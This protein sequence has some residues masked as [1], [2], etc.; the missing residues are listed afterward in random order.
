MSSHKN[1]LRKA[2][3]PVAGLGTRF[4]PVTKASPKEMLPVVDKPLIQYAVEEAV[5][6][7]I[8]VLIFVNN[9][10]KRAIEDYFDDARE[11][12][13]HLT[14]KNRPKLLEKI[15]DI[16]PAGV[17]CVYLRQANSDGLGDAVRCAEAVVHDEPFAVL[18]ADD[19]VR[20]DG[21]GCMTQLTRVWEREGGTVLALEEV[22]PENTSRYGIIGGARGDD[23]LWQV[24]QLVEKPP[25]GEA[26]SRMAVIGRYILQPDIFDHLRNT[27]PGVGGELQLTDAIAKQIDSQPVHG[28]CY[29]GQRYDCGDKL[30]YLRAN[31][32]YALQH[33]DL[34]DDFR[35][36][37]KNLELP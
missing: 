4:L 37:L 14:R 9:R 34:A 20:T 28:L 33:P 5:E 21:A 10:N 6:A 16:V 2:V 18:L 32:E 22:A 31:V 29:D 25:S 19:L 27:R 12:S 17:S 8:E 35:D 15:N 7:G 11:L 1:K 36:Y 13:D 30:G 26:P 24:E 23:G 3:F